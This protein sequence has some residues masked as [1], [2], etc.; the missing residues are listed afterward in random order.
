MTSEGVSEMFSHSARTLT[1]EEV[2]TLKQHDSSL[3]PEFKKNKLEKD[4]AK[5][6]DLFYKRN[7]TKF[8]KDRH[9]TRREFEELANLEENNAKKTILEVGCGV[10][11]FI[12]PLIEELK[13]LY[14]FACDFSPRAVDFVKENPLYD[15]TR[16]QAFVCDVAEPSSLLP[17][18]SAATVDIVSVIFVL[19]AIDPRRHAQV[20]ENVHQVLRP[21]GLV[22]F[23]DYGLYDQ[24]Q[25]RFSRGHKLQDNFY[26]R[27][28]GTRAY[29]FQDNALRTLFEKAGFVTRECRYVQRET[30]NRREGV[31]VPRIFVQG[32]FVKS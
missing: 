7:T 6:W 17:S 18:I 19:S 3:V 23:R 22:I 31:T 26:V 29:Y 1:S 16:C 30:S 2:E 15:E 14:V 13:N 28:D 25:L 11:N 24:A 8:Y 5:N 4:A 27:Q 21:G 9:W 12:F 10:G 20:L 32:R